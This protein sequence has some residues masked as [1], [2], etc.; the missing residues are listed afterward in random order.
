[1]QAVYRWWA[2]WVFA[3]IVIQVGLAG[4]GAFYVVGKTDNGG[5]VDSDKVDS[6]FGPHVVWGYLAV[7]LSIIILVLIG[8]IGGIGRWRLGRQ[9]ILFLLFV[10]QV[11]LA[12]GGYD[13]P[14]IGFFHPVNALVIFTLAGSIVFTTWRAH[15]ASPPAPSPPEPSTAVT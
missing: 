1:M 2:T 3:A 6:G 11:V 7:G 15:R 8:L 5:V 13:V 14:A 10:L 4:Y 9:G 12:G